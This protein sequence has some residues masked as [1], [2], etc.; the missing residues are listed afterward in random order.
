MGHEVDRVQQECEK[1]RTAIGELEKHVLRTETTGPG[2]EE[3]ELVVDSL[4][5]AF[6]RLKRAI[7]R[8]R[9]PENLTTLDAR[10]RVS[11][12]PGRTRGQ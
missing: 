4:E 9:A 7:E 1:M 6:R 3:I 8:S 2:A 10:P 11:R 5:K 12:A